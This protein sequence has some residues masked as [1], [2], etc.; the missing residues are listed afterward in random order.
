M[1]SQ[2]KQLTIDGKNQITTET[3]IMT[4]ELSIESSQYWLIYEDFS[5]L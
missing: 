1:V 3:E 2:T 5:I 4:T